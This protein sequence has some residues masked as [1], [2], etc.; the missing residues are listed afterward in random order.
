MASE[1]SQHV[2]VKPKT[3]DQDKTRAPAMSSPVAMLRSPQPVQVPAE[4]VINETPAPPVGASLGWAVALY[5]NEEGVSTLAICTTGCDIIIGEED[6]L[7]F[8]VGDKIK[9]LA[10]DESGWW[11]GELNGTEGFFPAN[12]VQYF[13]TTNGD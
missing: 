5:D 1:Q 4:P 13:P 12:Y 8:Q 2:W 7:I 3:S 6:E 10:K 11:T 9:I